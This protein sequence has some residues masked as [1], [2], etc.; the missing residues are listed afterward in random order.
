MSVRTGTARGDI[1]IVGPH[2]DAF[3]LL[4]KA[5]AD[6]DAGSGRSVHAYPLAIEA[7]S[8]DARRG[9]AAEGIED[10]VTRAG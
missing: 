10:H 6:E 5:L 9:A 1:D 3:V 8:G 4:A 2:R 7:L